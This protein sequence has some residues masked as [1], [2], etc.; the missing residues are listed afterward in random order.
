MV[1]A[2]ICI[3]FIS[4]SVWA[5]HLFT[6]GMNSNANGFFVLTKMIIAVP[7]GIKIFN[8]LGMIASAAGIQV[9]ICLNV[10][11]LGQGPVVPCIEE[12]ALIIRVASRKPT[13]PRFSKDY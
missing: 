8:W 11:D 13:Q 5:H 6:I 4:M 3:G 7:T 1:A 2:T 9:Q 12:Y 10:G